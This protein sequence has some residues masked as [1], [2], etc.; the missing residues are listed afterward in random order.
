[1]LCCGALP[2][3]TYHALTGQQWRLMVRGML[4]GGRKGNMG[5]WDKGSGKYPAGWMR[6]KERGSDGEGSIYVASMLSSLQV[7]EGV[8]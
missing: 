5:S 3:A 1:M 6:M 7:Q 8:E 4:I 2:K